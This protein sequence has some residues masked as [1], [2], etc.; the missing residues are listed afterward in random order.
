MTAAWE[1]L[2]ARAFIVINEIDRMAAYPDGMA[3]GGGTALT[4]QIDHRVSRDID[5]FLPDPQL[6]A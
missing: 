2:L 4:L 5:L 6:L 1:K 3:L